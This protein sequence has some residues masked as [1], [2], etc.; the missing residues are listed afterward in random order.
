MNYQAVARDYL[1]GIMANTN[2]E[3]RF[4]V[5]DSS[6]TGPIE[7][8][9]THST[10]T[11]Q[12]GLFSVQIGRGTPV[13]GVFAGINWPDGLQ[14]LQVDLGF[15]NSFINMGTSQ[16]LTVPYAFYAA[17]GTAGPPGPPG[18]QGDPGQ[19]GPQGPKGDPG[20]QGPKGDTGVAGPKGDPGIPGVKGDTGA[21][22]PQGPQ[23]APGAKGDT[24]AVGPQGPQGPPGTGGGGPDSSDVVEVD[25]TGSLTVSQSISTFAVI[26]GLTSTI[27]VPT[28]SKV[29]AETYGGFSNTGGG[30]AY[31]V[32]D[33][34]IFVDGVNSFTPSYQRIV[35]ANLSFLTGVP[36]YWSFSRMLNLTPGTHTIDVRA[37]WNGSS[38]G[39]SVNGNV[40]APSGIVGHPALILTT[41]QK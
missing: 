13:S 38:G 40:G 17:N 23:G 36:T 35:N 8:I 6:A 21:V 9:E 4:T 33:I 31:V 27:T 26:P 5:H 14:F 25:G 22:G 30:G 32:V 18:P 20:A 37:V 15:G 29:L 24:G 10:T 16:L 34:A 1:G 3:V 7:Y 11:N 19:A 28:N 2:I 41:I 39:G 12:F